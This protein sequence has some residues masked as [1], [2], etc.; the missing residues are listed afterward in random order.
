MFDRH[1]R[2]TALL[3]SFVAVTLRDAHRGLL[4]PHPRWNPG[5]VSAEQSVQLLV[6]RVQPSDFGLLR[7]NG[8][9]GTNG[10]HLQGGG[11][12][13][14]AGRRCGRPPVPAR[15]AASAPRGQTAPSKADTDTKEPYRWRKYGTKAPFRPAHASP[16]LC[17]SGSRYERR[18]RNTGETTTGAPRQGVK[19]KS[20]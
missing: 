16:Y 13:R 6:K 20:T 15:A 10:G 8:G 2:T 9:P 5:L 3:R 4:G 12:G 7:T 18:T 11:H 1:L 14:G 17:G 19:P